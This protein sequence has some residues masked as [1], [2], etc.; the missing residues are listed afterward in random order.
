[1]MLKVKRLE[2]FVYRAPIAAPVAVARRIVS[3][4]PTPS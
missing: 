3:G 2:A 4:M 1:M